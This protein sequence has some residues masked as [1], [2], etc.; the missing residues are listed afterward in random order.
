MYN[1]IDVTEDSES[2]VLPSEALKINGEYIENQ[3]SGYRTLNVK[4]REALS[5]DV[6]TYT[7]GIRDG[8]RIKSKRFPERIITVTYQIIAATNEEF[9]EAYNKLASVLNV[10]NAELIFDDEPDKFFIGTPCIID[11]VTPG[12][13]AVVGNFEILCADPFKY[14]VIEYE[15]TTDLDETSILVD[16]N[17]TYKAFPV[18]EADF[19]SEEEA[20]EDGESVVELSGNG[21]CGY[22]AFFTEDA[23]IIQIGDPDEVDGEDAYA[24]S[25]TLVN[26]VFNKSSSWGTAAKSQWSVN[27]AVSQ[28]EK[29]DGSVAMAIAY[30][31]ED[32]E[33]AMTSGTLLTATST[34]NAPTFHYTVKAKTLKRWETSVRIQITVTASLG[35]D[36]SYFGRGYGLRASIYDTAVWNNVTLKKTTDYWRGKTGHTVSTTFVIDGI[37]AS[38]TKISGMKFKVVRTDSLGTAGILAETACK[39]FK[40][41]AYTEPVAETYFLAPKSYGTGE[42]WHGP[43]ITRTIP[44]DATGDVGAVNFSLTYRQT[45]YG[46]ADYFPYPGAGKTSEGISRK[47]GYFAAELA[48]ESGNRVAGITISKSS[49]SSNKATM[50]FYVG[51]TAV[52]KSEVELV[53]GSKYF[54]KSAGNSTIQ[55]KGGTFVFKSGG[56]SVTVTKS[57]YADTKVTQ[58]TFVFGAY[59]STSGL[60]F[61]GIYW[62]KFIKDNCDTW[63]DIP[64][65]FSANDV[66]EADCSNGKIYM[67]GAETPAL[68]ALGNDWEDFCLTPGLNQIGVAYSNWVDAECAPTFKVR[69]REV[70]L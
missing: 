19:H 42:K 33:P 10:E 66:V 69:Y 23:K 60:E 51:T 45:M 28:L 20:S 21:D 61:N 64:N 7:T 26:S 54:G 36:S 50:R 13:N 25:Q 41:S 12:R 43:T 1:F 3:V 31:A 30:P 40:I 39:D 65:K 22:V 44:A 53:R 63:K 55:K 6:V 49:K 59:G 38:T 17:G 24:K 14:S 32:S 8:S 27:T 11:T 67:N 18:L 34:A 29:N 4:G 52:H 5:P 15:A 37:S 48:D 58:M 9:R 47:Y 35:R 16:Y 68:G 2:V 46:T 62:A 57:D 56:K 70:F